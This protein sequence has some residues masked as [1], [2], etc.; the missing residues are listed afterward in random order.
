MQ[1]TPQ[2]PGLESWGWMISVVF[3]VGCA[4]V[5]FVILRRYEARL[6]SAGVSR[7]LLLLRCLVL[8]L[9]LLVMLQPTLQREWNNDLAKRIVVG[10]D[11]SES[12]ATADRH[13]S[14]IEMLRWGQALGMLGNN[15][16]DSLISQWD[17]QLQSGQPVEWAADG[18]VAQQ[19]LRERH[20]SGVFGELQKMPRTEFVRRLLEAEPNELLSQL[21]DSVQVDLQAFGGRQQTVQP[22]VLSEFLGQDRKDLVPDQTDAIGMMAQSIAENA[23]AQVDA[24]VL[25]SDGRQ[26]PTTDAAA[27]L[28]QLESLGIPIYTVPIGSSRTPRDLSIAALDAPE[29][30]FLEDTAVVNAT[31]MSSGYEGEEITV[32]LFQND[33]LLQ[34]R[35]VAVSGPVFDVQF[36][37]PTTEIGTFDYQ[38]KTEIRDDELRK[39]NNSR[40]FTMGVDDDKARVWLVEGL[41]RWEFRYLK[42]ALERDSRVELSSVLFQQPFLDLLNRTFISRDVPSGAEL[43]AKLQSTDVLILGDVAATDLPPDFW[44]QVHRAVEN[45]GLSLVVIPGRKN[46]PFSHDS[47]KLN[48]LLP[49]VSPKPLLAERMFATTSNAPLSAFR[50]RPT[51][52]AADRTLFNFSSPDAGTPVTF[53]TLPG[54]LWACTGEPKPGASLWANLELNGDDVGAGL[55]HQYFGFG[56]VVWMGIDSTWR[57]RRRSGDRWHHRFWGELVRWAVGNKSTTGNQQ[58]RMS[59]SNVLI[60]ETESTDVEI[61]WQDEASQQQR[62]QAQLVIQKTDDVGRQQ[63]VQT[64]GLNQVANTTDRSNAVISDLEPGNYLV[65]LQMP[66]GQPMASDVESALIVQRKPSSEL[67]SISCNREFL[68][69]LSTATG[70]QMMEPWELKDLPEML[71]PEV[72]NQTQLESR[73]LWD[74]WPTMLLFFAL[75]TCEWV[76]RKI[77]GLP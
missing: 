28:A 44:D 38:L 58:V 2:L 27:Q 25:L 50:L 30:V 70:G 73:S 71:N 3:A 9:L 45:D 60:D 63:T 56:Q 53:A 23:D 10:F 54:H 8:L 26:T 42:G 59:L 17:S 21:Q 39:D 55:V 69:Q 14:Q 33:R 49:I 46:F 40:D 74:T 43:A 36:D 34:T 7:T 57:W 19:G 31:V 29:S 61:R 13:A 48:E 68:Q 11:V 72:A 75:L 66:D 64:V 32:E 15:I 12:M 16:P 67:A 1:W 24:I 22:D 77:N 62:E 51:A 18:N 35:D 5:L 52:M 20:V 4:L 41:A 47:Q 6:V 37:I 65:Q 76:I